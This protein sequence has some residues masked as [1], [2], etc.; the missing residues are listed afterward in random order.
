MNE[1]K[2]AAGLLL[3]TMACGQSSRQEKA[4]AT[5]EIADAMAPPADEP[6]ADFKGT[7]KDAEEPTSGYALQDR[8][9]NV[10]AADVSGGNGISWSSNAKPI[11]N[12]G[13]AIS[14][15]AAVQGTDTVHRFIRT[16]DLRFRVNDVV[17][18]TLAWRT[19]LVRIAGGSLEL[20]CAANPG[21]RR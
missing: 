2:I 7:D 15:S 3:L 6:M 10:V 16:A 20:H 8:S 1:R 11:P 14:S 13:V 4:P 9:T 5:V 12:V 18:A 21:A 19:S 17:T